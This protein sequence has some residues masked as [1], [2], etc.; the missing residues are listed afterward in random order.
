MRL[1][2]SRKK[3]VRILGAATVAA[4]TGSVNAIEPTATVVEFYNAALDHYLIATSPREVA[5]LD[6]NVAIPG[7]KRTG[8]EWKAW[9]RATDKPGAAPACR[10]SAAGRVGP[11]SYY[12]T[13]NADECDVAR[14]SPEWTYEGIAFWIDVPDGALPSASCAAGTTP[15]YGSHLA[16]SNARDISF[17]YVTDLTLQ[18]RMSRGSTPDGV[19]MCA[20]LS[21]AQIDAD[22]VRFLEQA[23]WGP[24]EALIRQVRE[25][26]I[27][28]YLDAQLAMPS[29]RYTSFAPVPSSRPD[30]CIDDRTLPLTAVSF[31]ARDNYTLFQLQRE[32]FRHA[33]EAP[34]QLRQ[35]VAFALSQILVTSG[36][37]INRV[38]A[39]QRYQQLL[40]D[41]AFGNFQAVLTE[42]TLSPAMGNYL[43]MANNRK[44]NP[45]TGIEP[46]ENYARELMQLFSIG[47]VEV[48]LDG[49]P[50]KDA[51]GKPIATYGQDEIEGF[52]HV[53][54]GWTYPTAPGAAS[55]P[56]NGPY[57]DGP[58]EERSAFH[59]YGAKTLID[60]ATA[61]AG[62]SMGADLA[63]AIRAVF[64]HPNVGPFIAKQL[65]QK[66]VTGDPTPGFVARI[67]TVFNDNGSGV[68]GDLRAVVRA[69]LLDPE[70]RGAT[71]LDP[72]YGKLR[73]P[74]KFVAGAA[75]VLNA[76]TDGVFFR[77]Q[78]AAMGQ[79]IFM[80]PSVFNY[81][82]PDY[83][84][85]GTTSLGPEFAIQ[86]TSTALARANFTNTLAFAAA[87]APDATV[88]GATGTNVDWTP[89]AALAGNPAV[90]IDRLDRLLMHGTLS[91]SAKSAIETA[92]VV[93]PATDPVARAKTAFY[94]IITSSQYQVER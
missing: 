88:Y 82:P 44:A 6:A 52:A 32:F 46:N 37:D 79:P 43:D 5:A 89:W 60:G 35:R 17:R 75:R 15:V 91:T 38:Y 76:T 16:G 65:I 81:Y 90:L 68:R 19:V 58:M 93:I 55:R 42:V 4:V 10:F 1:P 2:A 25:R 62:L 77:A 83:V 69:I 9:A 14:R 27:A 21:S 50:L 94:L 8:V 20:P 33:V 24:T 47:T 72:G 11:D 30:T 61:A 7:W 12:Y 86:N 87:I 57:Y 66:L 22:V 26:G 41:L 71:K 34:D 45:V 70:A 59:D 31:C 84:V 85:P 67:A 74:A 28:A 56:L 29:T 18:A 36:T 13:A 78:T 80:A 54:T 63:N 3:M 23:T 73:E 48:A 40:A 64:M 39:M 51:D 92:V 49:T 53:F